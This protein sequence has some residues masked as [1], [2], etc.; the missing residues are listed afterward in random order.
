MGKKRPHSI[1]VS[2][3]QVWLQRIFGPY[4][5]QTEFEVIN[6]EKVLSKVVEQLDLNTVWGR[7][8]QNGEKLKT[9]ETITLLKGRMAL[10]PV[11]N[12]S[13]IEIRVFSENAKEAAKIANAVAEAYR[14]HRQ[15]QRVVLRQHDALIA[16]ADGH[17]VVGAADALSTHL[18]AA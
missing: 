4:F 7:K 3:L 2:L 16:I 18:A 8:Y 15:E 5:I 10:R 1:A 9:T 14:E 11:R 12:T 17:V 13:L 6:S